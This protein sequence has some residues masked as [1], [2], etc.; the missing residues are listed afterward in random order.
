MTKDEVIKAWKLEV[1]DWA[2]EIDPENEMDWHALFVG[3]AMGKGLSPA[4][5]LD[6]SFYMDR[7]FP[8]EGS[9]A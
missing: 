4:D 6:Y 3:F 5:A 9:G 1:C 8:L 7:A 2:G